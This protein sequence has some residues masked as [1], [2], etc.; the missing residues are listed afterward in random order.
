MSAANRRFPRWTRKFPVVES[1]LIEHNGKFD[2]LSTR[3][4]ACEDAIE[5]FRELNERQATT[6]EHTQRQ[7][8]EAESQAVEQQSHLQGQFATL[9]ASVLDLQHKVESIAGLKP[10]PPQ[11]PGQ[12]IPLSPPLTPMISPSRL[13]E[14]D[15]TEQSCQTNVDGR[16]TWSWLPNAADCWNAVEDYSIE[17]MPIS[18]LLS[19]IPFADPEDQLAPVPVTNISAGS[20][21]S[22]LDLTEKENGVEPSVELGEDGAGMDLLASPPNSVLATPAKTPQS[23]VSADVDSSIGSLSSISD[24]I[25]VQAKELADKETDTQESPS[26]GQKLR[27]QFVTRLRQLPAPSQPSDFAPFLTPE[28]TPEPELPGNANEVGDML[29]MTLPTPIHCF[30]EDADYNPDSNLFSCDSWELEDA[31]DT[32]A[33]A[34][35]I[36]NEAGGFTDFTPLREARKERPMSRAEHRFKASA[37]VK[38]LHFDL[39][40][41]LIDS[42]CEDLWRGGLSPVVT[43]DGTARVDERT[44]HLLVDKLG[45]AKEVA[46]DSP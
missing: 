34:A 16:S 29:P 7:L 39:Q 23:H 46:T 17:N 43:W 19:P 37:K 15:D 42:G 30:P 4:L 18:L 3:V 26:Y 32:E 21:Y 25:F 24:A 38:D 45:W 9:E 5:K 33:T 35:M 22:A 36:L 14:L 44:K 1:T 11:N 10:Q 20:N 40:R 31:D 27:R 8:Q 28:H 13:P 41:R 6:I 12:T 2:H